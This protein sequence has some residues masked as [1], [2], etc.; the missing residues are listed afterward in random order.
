MVNRVN[1]VNK[2]VR[3]NRVRSK[4]KRVNRDAVSFTMFP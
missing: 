3:V 4:V 1:R 2:R